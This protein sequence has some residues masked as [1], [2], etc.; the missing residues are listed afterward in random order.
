MGQKENSAVKVEHMI[1]IIKDP[2]HSYQNVDFVCQEPVLIL[3]STA[4]YKLYTL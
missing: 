1:H 2:L 3:M 4:M